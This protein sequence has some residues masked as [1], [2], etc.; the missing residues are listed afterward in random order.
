[1]EN[2]RPHLYLLMV[3]T[4]S[5]RSSCQMEMPVVRRSRRGV[6]GAGDERYREVR[7]REGAARQASRSS[8]SQS[9]PGCDRV[10]V[11]Q[12]RAC[13]SLPHCGCAVCDAMCARDAARATPDTRVRVMPARP[14]G[15]MDPR[16]PIARR[17]ARAATSLSALRRSAL[18]RPPR[19]C[20]RVP[21]VPA[22]FARFRVAYF[23][24]ECAVTGVCEL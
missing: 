6:G 13:G 22:P 12:H 1:M 20:C 11:G 18:S 8:L 2:G 7:E 14:R 15:A 10:C 3:W 4:Q 21:C 16:H 23:L 9:D 24:V 19:V 17:G 5:Q